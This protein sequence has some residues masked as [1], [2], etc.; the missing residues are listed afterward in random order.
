M[1]QTVPTGK[2][3][4][5]MDR[6]VDPRLHLPLSLQNNA[7]AAITAPI[8]TMDVSIARIHSE[9][10]NN[11]TPQVF[12]AYTYSTGAWLL[13]QSIPLI[14]MPRMI[15]TMLLDEARPPSRMSRLRSL[16]RPMVN[17]TRNTRSLTPSSPRNL[18]LPLPRLRPPHHRP[19][20]RH[21][22][23]LRA[24]LVHPLRVY[25]YRRK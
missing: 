21:A 3:H 11:L 6:D 9:R 7:L 16:L 17:A 12:Y 5:I 2:P 1:L 23:R 18:P 19:P 10:P 8:R 4:D 25:I 14:G 20:H 13:L 15:T 22:D 24:P